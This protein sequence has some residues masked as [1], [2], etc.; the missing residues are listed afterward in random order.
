[1]EH[2][3]QNIKKLRTAKNVTQEQLANSLHISNQAV[4]KWEKEQAYPDIALLP[5][6]AD[7][8][9]VSMDELFGYRPDYLTYKERFVRFM[10]NNNILQFG[11]F[12]LK[13]GAKSKHYINTE[14]FTTNA[15]IAKIGEFFADCIRENNI[16]FNT[17]LGLAYH[18]IA[19]SGATAY[20]LYQKYG[21]TINYCYDRKASDS[22][23]RILCGYTLQKGDKVVVIDDLM[24]S[25]KTLDERLERILARYDVEIAAVIVIADRKICPAGSD[26]TGCEMIAEKY[27]TRVYSIITEDDIINTLQMLP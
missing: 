9:S 23:D 20:A 15:Q 17:C 21:L 24:S 2:I 1:M 14:N 8:F 11:D 6:I 27:N 16:D 5:M 7:Y 22:R 25:G 10:M 4:S 26:K 19:I 12:T 3:G 13:S 18:G